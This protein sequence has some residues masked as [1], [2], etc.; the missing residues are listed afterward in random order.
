MKIAGIRYRVAA[1]IIDVIIVSVI[2][3]LLTFG[4]QKSRQ[5]TETKND[6]GRILSEYFDSKISMNEAADAAFENQYILDK[7]DVPNNLIELV[8]T[9]GYF[10]LFAYYNKG[11]TFGKKLVHIRVIS[12]DGEDANYS[13]LFG[14]A[15]II[16]GCLSSIISLAI[17]GFIKPNQYVHTIGLIGLL[18]SIMIIC[19][20][21][22]VAKR[23]DGRGLHDIISKTRVIE[24]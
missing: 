10:V 7:E 20:I 1:Y 14:R 5:Y 9:V 17:I 12:N 6:M 21:I 3:S 11:Q 15:L 22:M 24:C 18:Q 2:V 4:I 8:I 19:T 23:K 16:N 13:Q